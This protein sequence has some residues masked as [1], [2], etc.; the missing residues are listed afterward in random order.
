[1]SNR[2]KNIT[3][4]PIV[5]SWFYQPP[6]KSPVEDELVEALDTVNQRHQYRM[7]WHWLAVAS[8]GCQQEPKK[9][10]RPDAHPVFEVGACALLLYQPGMRFFK[11]VGDIAQED[12]AEDDVFVFGGVSIF[13]EFIGRFPK[14]GG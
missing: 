5:S 12:E 1:M 11:G 13:A 14:L 2:R 9:H 4:W 6:R 3:N 7:I 8:S 10:F